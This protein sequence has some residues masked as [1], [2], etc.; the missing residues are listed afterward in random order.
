VSEIS[1]LSHLEGQS[2]VIRFP[3]RRYRIVE[4]QS[5]HVAELVEA[6]REDDK[7]ELTDFGMTPKKALWRSY[8]RAFMRR[9]AFVDGEIA[10]MWGLGG[11][12]LAGEAEAWLLTTAAVEKLPMA[13]A[14]EGRKAALQMIELR[15]SIF[16]HVAANYT[17]AIRLMKIL[18]FTIDE[19]KPFGP[20]DTLFCRIS[21]SRS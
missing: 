5:W 9:T 19:P 8:R 18:G 16:G 7:I 12:L 3:Q 21:M 17:K 13:F 10:A 1:G 11:G 20:N 6:M 14:K 15:S 4:S 2:V